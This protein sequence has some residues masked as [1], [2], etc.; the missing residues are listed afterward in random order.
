[1]A[2]VSMFIFFVAGAVEFVERGMH[3]SIRKIL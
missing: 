3:G 1:M 2:I